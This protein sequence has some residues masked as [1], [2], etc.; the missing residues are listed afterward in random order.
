[1]KNI[2]W[3]MVMGG[4][5]IGVVHAQDPAPTTDS[6][7]LTVEGV[8]DRAFKSESGVLARIRALQPI[9]EVYIQNMDE[10]LG[11]TPVR[12]EY[13]LGQFRW[14]EAQGPQLLPLAPERGNLAHSVGF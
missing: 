6:S 13:Y 3:A 12:D 1:M 2:I 5:A 14:S 11:T 4:V 10:K 9:V 8:A 7:G